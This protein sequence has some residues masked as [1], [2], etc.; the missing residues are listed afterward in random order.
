[1]LHSVY[2]KSWNELPSQ[3]TEAEEMQKLKLNAYTFILH[4]ELNLSPFINFEI[5]QYLAD[6]LL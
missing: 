5:F 2:T 4:L 1:M 6:L 3:T